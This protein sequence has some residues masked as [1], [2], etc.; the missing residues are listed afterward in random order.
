M[1]RFKAIV[2]ILPLLTFRAH[3]ADVK[4]GID[5][6]REIRPILSDNCFQWH[7]P[8][9]KKRMAGLRLDLKEGAFLQTRRGSIITPGDSSKSLLF[10]RINHADK[11]RRMPPP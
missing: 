9:E 3:A 6:N 11:D 8:D 1:I 7:G 10:Q 5:F 4:T 2:L